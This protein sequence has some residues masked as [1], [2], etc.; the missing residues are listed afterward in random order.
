M[1]HQQIISSLYSINN[2]AW[3]G[4]W[5]IIKLEFLN[6]IKFSPRFVLYYS[7]S[8]GISANVV[9]LNGSFLFKFLD[10]WDL[11]ELYFEHISPFSLEILL[12]RGF[13]FILKG[14]ELF[15]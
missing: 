13:M 7:D 9:T 8:L 4:D 12:Y 6:I 10:I 1:Y 11:I 15:F 2:F 5:K 14:I 3:K